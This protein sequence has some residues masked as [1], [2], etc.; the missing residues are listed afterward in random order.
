MPYEKV[1]THEVGREPTDNGYRPS[2]APKWD[3]LQLE[4]LKDLEE[5]ELDYRAQPV[6]IRKDRHF[7]IYMVG[8]IGF[9]SLVLGTVSSLTSA[10]L[11]TPF[12]FAMFSAT[13]VLAGLYKLITQRV[14]WIALVYTLLGPGLWVLAIIPHWVRHYPV[15]GYGFFLLSLGLTCYLASRI[16]THYAMWLAASPQLLGE[17]RRMA[18]AQWENR[19]YD[20]FAI[21]AIY[22][23]LLIVFASTPI[24]G[25]RNFI[26]ITLFF[27]LG[28]FYR[29]T[30]FRTIGETI[31]LCREAIVSWFTYSRYQ[32]VHFDFVEQNNQMGAASGCLVTLLPVAFYGVTIYLLMNGTSLTKA[33]KGEVDTTVITVIMVV[34]FLVVVNIIFWILYGAYQSHGTVFPNPIS[35]PGL[36]KS[37]GGTWIM[38]NVLAA[39][40][41]CALFTTTIHFISY[42]PLGLLSSDSR[43]ML[44]AFSRVVDKKI[45]LTSIITHL[46]N[47]KPLTAAEVVKNLSK[48]EVLLLKKLDPVS[49]QEYVLS[50]QTADYLTTSPGAWVSLTLD[51]VFMGKGQAVWAILLGIVQ[52]LLFPILIFLMTCLAVFGRALPRYAKKIDAL[53]SP[54][55]DWQGYV[56]RLQHSKVA[57]ARE[58]LWLGVHAT[59]DY[60]VLLHRSILGEHAHLLG[61]SGSGKTALGMAPLLAQLVSLRD[62]AVVVIDL[63]GDMP[64]FQTAQNG[65]GNRFKF[66]TNEIG[67]ATYAFNP[68]GPFSS[69]HISLNQVCEV[70]LSALGL[71]HGEG[72]GRSYYSRV[73]RNLLSRTIQEYPDIASFEE[74]R[75]KVGKLTNTI[76][77]E[78]DA[79]EL[80]AVVES[81]ATIHQLN[82]TA[83]DLVEEQA[84][85]MATVVKNREVVYFWLPAAIET[86]S[87]RE[88]AKLALYTLFTSAYQHQREH[89][90]T[91]KIWVFVDEFQHVASL[92]FKLLLQQAR[93]MG[94]GMILAN[95]TDSDLWTR[96]LDLKGTVQTNTRFKQ[97]FSMSNLEERE[98]LSKASGE[99]LYYSRRLD[100]AGNVTTADEKV[101]PRLMANDIIA[102][103]DEPDTSIVLISRGH[104][105]SQFGGYAFPLRGD[106]HITFEE[107]ERRKNASWPVPS[108]HTLVTHR[109][110]RTEARPEAPLLRTAY[111]LSDDEPPP[112]VSEKVTASPWAKHLQ[113]LYQA[114]RV[115]DPKDRGTAPASE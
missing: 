82:Y 84:I 40:T 68:F 6:L 78:K 52:C 17:K 38:R 9:L 89:H 64:L 14:R 101:G 62:S 54:V 69:D 43:P 8:L 1:R 99:T 88:I 98:E 57:A 108:A 97:I 44:A 21:I 96:D 2:T 81:L 76:S 104:G 106:Y 95:Q 10:Y 61:D 24:L 20:G 33:V 13:G 107:Y 85:N 105:Y 11:D 30:G 102:L 7:V 46:D 27:A 75:D 87:V 25:F 63:K 47:Y 79:F 5:L 115:I 41:L 109:K 55:S 28:I 53:K 23:L 91:P 86:A 59:E 92:N 94:M 29:V 112:E 72:Y 48:G 56:N 3:V 66:F 4:R 65:A 49:Q 111:I 37:P 19:H 80:I 103:S 42:A 110:R 60:P 74:L 71:D 31:S 26:W 16:A 77:D 35:P 83:K 22:G 114:R 32:A 100:A 58:H 34:I 36:F 39:V 51:S 67:K 18:Q 50:K 15:I 113:A 73:A 70:F 45:S 90:E 12:L 93:S